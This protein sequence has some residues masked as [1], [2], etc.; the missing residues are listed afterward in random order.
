[1]SIN[2]SFLY[3][4]FRIDNVMYDR[5]KFALYSGCVCLFESIIY[6]QAMVPALPN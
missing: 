1:M 6:W 5:Y 4:G 2:I 3:S